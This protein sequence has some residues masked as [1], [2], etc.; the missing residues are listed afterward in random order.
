MTHLG[1]L[2]CSIAC[3]NNESAKHLFFECDVFSHF[4]PTVTKWLKIYTA[5]SIVGHYHALQFG[6][7]F[8]LIKR[9][10]SS[11]LQFS[12]NYSLKRLLHQ[13]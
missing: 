9:H 8:C 5:F 3:G 12:W 10:I 13:S 11:S 1:S 6:Y 7:I 4:W 2:L